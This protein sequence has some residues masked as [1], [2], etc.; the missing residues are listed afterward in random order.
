MSIERSSLGLYRPNRSPSPTRLQSMPPSTID[1][2]IRARIESFTHE[3]AELVKQVAVES[4]KDAMKSGKP[5]RRTKATKPRPGRRSSAQV[6]AMAAKVLAHVKANQGHRLE[7]IG[8]ALRVP[9]KDLKRPVANLLEAKKLR[10]EGQKR[11]TKYF[12]GAA[13][14]RAGSKKKAARKAGKRKAAKKAGRKASK[15]GAKRKATKNRPT[16]RKAT[17]KRK[18]VPTWPEAIEAA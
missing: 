2:E 7:E 15:R 16:R 4:V 1:A 17:T 13:R 6:D 9:T 8:V 18:V 12:A 14:K 3:L 5:T 11:G 10:T